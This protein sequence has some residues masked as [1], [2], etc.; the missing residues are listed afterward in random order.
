MI[1][2]VIYGALA[3]ATCSIS[4][5]ARNKTLWKLGVLFLLNWVVTITLYAGL[6][7]DW[8]SALSFC[9]DTITATL[10]YII[11]TIYKCRIGKYVMTVYA[12]QAC[13]YL[14]LLYSGNEYATHVALNA[15]F[16]LNA[17]IIIFSS[18]KTMFSKNRR[19]KD[20]KCYRSDRRIN[21]RERNKNGVEY[22]WSA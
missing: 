7:K 12:S 9:S 16:I 3:I 6:E 4:I 10:C 5:A 2:V 1:F 8:Q 11:A 22:A 14:Y 21:S 18:L 15:L 19:V 13:L 17:G 20:I